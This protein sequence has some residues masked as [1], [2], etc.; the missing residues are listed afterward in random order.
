MREAHRR[1]AFQ[2][3]RQNPKRALG[4]DMLKARVIKEAHKNQAMYPYLLRLYVAC[5]EA[6]QPLAWRT[7]NTVVLRKGEKRDWALPKSYRP[8]SLLNVMGKVLEAIIQQRLTH[9]TGD[10]PKE[11]F[12]RR[13]RYSA[14]D[15]VLTLIQDAQLANKCIDTRTTALMVDVK[16]RFDEVHRDTLLSTLGTLKVPKTV[17]RW[18]C[19][20]LTGRSISLVVDSRH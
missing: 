6:D 18:V 19:S 13:S 14:P 16:A 9:I 5:T 4:S 17:I 10:T 3:D 7:R 15:A 11:P 2:I 20:F 8:N 12:G 1:G